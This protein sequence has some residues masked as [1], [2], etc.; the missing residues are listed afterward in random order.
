MRGMESRVLAP[1]ACA[2]VACLAGTGTAGA[3]T[4]RGYYV[5]CAK[6]RDAAAG[7][8]P[9]T[10]WRTLDRASAAAL[11]PGDAIRFKRG[12]RCV[13]VFA[14]TRSGTKAKPIVAEPYGAGKRRPV[15]DGGGARWAVHLENV[16]GWTVRGLAVRNPGSTAAVGVLRSGIHV[17]NTSAGVAAGITIEDNLVSD[18]DTARTTPAGENALNYSKTSGG[19]QLYATAPNGFTDVTI[20]RN[21]IQ[22]LAREGIFVRGGAPTK[23]L[24]I[25]DNVVKDID[26]DGIVAV[27]AAK[28]LIERNVVDGFNQG[29][30]VSNA[31]MWAYDSTD[32]VFQ[33]NDVSHGANGTLDGMAY[34]IDGGNERLTFQY[35]LSRDNAGGFVMF[36]GD[37]GETSGHS[38]VRYNVSQNDSGQ[39]THGVLAMPCGPLTDI[40]VYNNTVYTKD[41]SAAY[42]IL[43]GS[44]TSARFANNVLVGPGSSVIGDSVSTFDHNLYAGVTCGVANAD[45]APVVADPAFVRAGKARSLATADGYRLRKGSPAIGAGVAIPGNGGRDFFG[46]AVPRTGRP[47]IGAYQGPGVGTKAAASAANAPGC[48]P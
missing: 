47:N 21:T 3:A 38:V 48:A 29:G 24:V 42:M 43:N 35:N 23:R 14:P 13:G 34:D 11:R 46:N 28:A 15:I 1:L 32:V 44:H 31:G 36:C 40:Q 17:D 18:V 12:A 45:P 2:V 30:V 39:N 9:A 41:P 27:H 5:D 10:A 7:T 6:G 8:S 22:H 26:G 16:Q 19:I 33:F 25:R 37:P 20:R 4:A